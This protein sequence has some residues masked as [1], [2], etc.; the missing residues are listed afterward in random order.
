MSQAS[1]SATPHYAPVTIIPDLAGQNPPSLLSEFNDLFPH[2]EIFFNASRI[3]YVGLKEEKH[4]R[5]YPLQS[6]ELRRLIVARYHEKFDCMP[7]AAALRECLAWM[8]ARFSRL[9][10][11]S[12]AFTR[13]G[14]ARHIYWLDLGDSSGQ[15]VRLSPDLNPQADPPQ[16]GWSILPSP[17]VNLRRSAH[18]RPLPF[19]ETGPALE[20]DR[21]LDFQARFDSLRQ[22]SPV[23]SES[24]WLLLLGWLTAVLRSDFPIPALCLVG[25]P[26]SGKTSFARLLR[27]LLDPSAL[28][29]LPTGLSTAALVSVLDQHAL[30]VFDNLSRLSRPQSNFFCRAVTGGGFL[31]PDFFGDSRFISFRRPVIFTALEPPSLSPDWLDRVLL[32]SLKPPAQYLLESELGEKFQ[33]HHPGPLSAF[34]DLFCQALQFRALHHSHPN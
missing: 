13:F 12:E 8:D 30:P 1:Q 9:S 32:L 15:A 25:P 19:P 4:W 18:H 27:R 24:D 22:L 5:A 10:N 29:L 20:Q 11:A 3:P 6:P 23:L 21:R 34:F 2:A 31:S 26:G 33:R 16:Y 14:R 7:S 17:A 28:D